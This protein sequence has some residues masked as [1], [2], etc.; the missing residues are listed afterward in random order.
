MKEE[1]NAL[2]FPIM[3]SLHDGDEKTFN[4]IF[5]TYHS[6]LYSYAIKILKDPEEAKEVIQNVYFRLWEKRNKININLL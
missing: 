2:E 5:Q 1:V 6:Y 4:Y 3:S